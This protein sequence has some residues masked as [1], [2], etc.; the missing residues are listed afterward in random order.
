MPYETTLPPRPHKGRLTEDE[1]RTYVEGLDEAQRALYQERKEEREQQRATVGQRPGRRR[2]EPSL[3][4]DITVTELQQ[5]LHSVF[6]AA[7]MLVRSDEEWTDDEFHSISKG[8][9]VVINK[10]PP[11]KLVVRFLTP[12]ASVAQIFQKVRKLLGGVRKSN[13]TQNTAG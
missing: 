8:L 11:L 10:V 7:S 12:I 5:T 2:R 3:E 1:E 13:K 4:D 9:I 6:E